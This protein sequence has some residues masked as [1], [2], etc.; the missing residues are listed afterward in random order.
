M[1]WYEKK[2]IDVS[3]VVGLWMSISR[4][5]GFR[6]ISRSRKLTHPLFL[7]VGLSFI[8]VY[9]WFMCVLMRAG[10][11]LLVSYTIMIVST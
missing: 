9:I 6:I 4:L 1:G 7:Y 11:V 3:V 10:C 5:D 8:F 2:L